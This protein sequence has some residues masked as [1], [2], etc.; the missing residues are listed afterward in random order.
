MKYSE[1]GS[2]S[3]PKKNINKL[4]PISAK[5]VDELSNSHPAKSLLPFTSSSSST[6]A[7]FIILLRICLVLFVATAFAF[8]FFYTSSSSSNPTH[9]F[10]RPLSKLKSP[11]VLL[12]SMD[13][14]RFGYQYKT[15]TPNI[16][17]LIENGTE[18]KRGLIPVFPTMTFPNHYSIVTG[19][20][21]T[22]HGIIANYFTDPQTGDRFTVANHDPK[23]WLGEPLWET[24]V[25]HGLK[26]SAYFWPGSEVHKGSW[27]CP[28][29][30]CPKY[31]QNVPFEDRVDTVLKYFDLASDEIP[32]FM[33]LYFED[34]DSQGHGVGPDDPRITEA[35]SRMDGIIGRLI[36]GLE[37]RGLFED[38][39]IILVGDHGMVGTCD[40][41]LIFLEDLD[42]PEEWV[43]LAG[44]VLAIRPPLGASHDEVVLGI[45]DKLKS[46][47]VNN[48]EYLKVY[49]KE[50]LALERLHYSDSYRIPPILGMVGE[51]FKVE[52]R[53]TSMQECGGSHGYDNAFFSM[54]TIFIAHG[55]R[56]AKGKKVE[57]FENVQI[58]NVVT[59]LLNIQGAENNG[60]ASFPNTV[61]LPIKA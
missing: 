45:N 51:G 35:V 50:D 34:P 37:E 58:Y 59:K 30:F 22:Y 13:G 60:T 20:Y 8:L 26:A 10:S 52:Q 12:I 55:P 3:R 19:L 54:R 21:P 17:R 49:L 1:M 39:N 6:T 46:G 40:Q 33:S 27:D 23:W 11:V 14:F 31:D 25:K 61:I 4:I 53:N 38:V 42:V 29:D 47:K 16:D 36:K 56:F 43:Q 32:S 57:S 24:A 9:E 7:V 15:D 2:S 44:P 28:K 48:G 18:A 41:K 5:E